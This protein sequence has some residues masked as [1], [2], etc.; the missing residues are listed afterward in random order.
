MPVLVVAE[1][2]GERLQHMSKGDARLATATFGQ[3][4]LQVLL[5][6]KRV[7]AKDLG[8]FNLMV[9]AVG[10]VL[11]VDLNP[12]SSDQHA[13]CNAKSLQ[14]AHR[15]NARFWSPAISYAT[16]R[17]AEVA[18]FVARLAAAIP[19]TPG[20]AE[21]LFTDEHLSTLRTDPAAAVA[22][23]KAREGHERPS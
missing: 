6:S 8:P 13:R 17:P 16:H 9:D 2:E 11:Q 19:H 5:F 22:Q 18:D 23:W 4:L 3:T 10:R 15:F 20:L 7:G 12:I 21:D 1:F 14:T